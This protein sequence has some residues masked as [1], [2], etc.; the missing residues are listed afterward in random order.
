MVSVLELDFWIR[1]IEVPVIAALVVVIW[2]QQRQISDLRLDIANIRVEVARDYITKRA[3]EHLETSLKDY[4]DKNL[5]ARL[6]V[7]EEKLERWTH[8]CRPATQKD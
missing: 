7:M 1:V 5:I 2:S 8:Q 4:I 6:S 3:L